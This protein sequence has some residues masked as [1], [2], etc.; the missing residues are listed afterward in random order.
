MDSLT[1]WAALALT[2]LIV[3]G[4]ELWLWQRARHHPPKMS[5]SAHVLLRQ[6]WVEAL[7]SH[8]DS[9]IVAVQVLRNSLMSSTISASTAALMLMGC[10]TLAASTGVVQSLTHGALG[11]GVRL[12]LM[13]M[14]L[15]TLFATYVCSAMSMRYF[16]HAGFVMSLPVGST[17]RQHY[18]PMCLAYVS[19]GGVLYGWGLRCFLF[20]APLV[21]GLIVPHLMPVAA[22][23]LVAMLRVFDHAGPTAQDA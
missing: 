1:D 18:Q 8:K 6:Q 7:S 10:A 23:L 4:Y 13:L 5:R 20:M 14:I 19:R 11:G 3:A 15:G 22:L 9:E 21:T 16:N 17:E 12:V 2:V